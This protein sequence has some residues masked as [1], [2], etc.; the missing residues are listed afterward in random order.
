MSE[1]TITQSLEDVMTELTVLGSTKPVQSL[2]GEFS[3]VIKLKDLINNTEKILQTYLPEEQSKMST[4][5]TF[6]HKSSENAL[7]SIINAGKLDKN[8]I[9]PAIKKIQGKLSRINMEF[10]AI[11]QDTN[12]P[13]EDLEREWPFIGKNLIRPHFYSKALEEIGDEEL[14]EKCNLLNQKNQDLKEVRND[15]AKIANSV[16]NTR[17]AM[18]PEKEIYLGINKDIFLTDEARYI[19]IKKYIQS[20]VDITMPRGF[21]KEEIGQIEQ[22][23]IE[24]LLTLFYVLTRINSYLLTFKMEIARRGYNNLMETEIEKITN[25][26]ISET[27]QEHFEDLS[28]GEASSLSYNRSY[29]EE[30]D[31][32]KDQIKSYHA[33]LPNYESFYKLKNYIKSKLF[34]KIFLQE[35]GLYMTTLIALGA[36]RSINKVEINEGEPDKDDLWDRRFAGILTLLNVVVV[37]KPTLKE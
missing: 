11:K 30:R 35:D 5:A 19:P 10:E 17:P 8:D 20:G 34:E 28:T 25:M 1:M 32:I 15:L 6:I 26:D 27:L 7:F 14:L 36:T 29:E 21:T 9:Y 18:D 4:M 23:F 2:N 12:K 22:Y 13:I 31:S 24:L 37:S 16:T 3:N 33:V